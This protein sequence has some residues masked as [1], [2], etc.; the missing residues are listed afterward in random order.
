MPIG[1]AICFKCDPTNLNDENSKDNVHEGNV[2]NVATH[3]TFPHSAMPPSNTG[4]FCNSEK[5]K[6]DRSNKGSSTFVERSSAL[7]N[8]PILQ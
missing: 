6:M 5:L 4:S 1:S 2:P 7:E 8:N 3:I